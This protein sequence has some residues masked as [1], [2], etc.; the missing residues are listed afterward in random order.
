ME[1]CS[2]KFQR[3]IDYARNCVLIC[4]AARAYPQLDQKSTAAPEERPTGGFDGAVSFCGAAYK[5]R[6]GAQ[7]NANLNNARSGCGGVA[8][9]LVRVA[10][11]RGGLQRFCQPL[12][13]AAIP[14]PRLGRRRAPSLAF[15][16][17]QIV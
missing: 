16:G 14:A 17:H 1:I 6:R 13:I 3:R 8:S 5:Q 9:G 11:R 12:A 2:L 10:I 4:L 15:I 7:V